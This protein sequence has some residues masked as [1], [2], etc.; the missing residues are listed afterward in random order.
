[1]NVITR[2][3][4]YAERYRK[5][6]A[7]AA[8]PARQNIW[9]SNYIKKEE[10]VLDNKF[11]P[12]NGIGNINLDSILK[13]SNLMNNSNQRI[14]DESIRNNQKIA[15]SIYEQKQEE[16]RLKEKDSRNIE[17][18]AQNSE[19]IKTVLS[20]MNQTLQLI[21]N[22]IEQEAQLT[23]DELRE[24]NKLLYEIKD[25]AL[26]EEPN[27][28]TESKMLGILKQGLSVGGQASMMLFL[29]T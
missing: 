10:Y 7:G 4:E 13:N 20:S 11:K 12:L 21:V 25:I 22:T 6:E 3:R 2:L 24:M 28:E 26:S 17:L 15:N 19:E 8:R 18:T 1:M 9:V 27:Q 29:N 16:K 23:Q 14:Y 5:D